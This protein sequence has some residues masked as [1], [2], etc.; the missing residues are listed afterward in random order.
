MYQ[1]KIIFSLMILFLISIFVKA[2]EDIIV[3]NL[4]YEISPMADY[5]VT[6]LNNDIETA[7]EHLTQYGIAIEPKSGTQ[8]LHS[9]INAIFITAFSSSD[10]EEE[11]TSIEI[12]ATSFD[13]AH[14]SPILD[15]QYYLRY[16]TDSQ[17]IDIIVGLAL[18]NASLFLEAEEILLEH[19]LDSPESSANFYIGNIRLFQQDYSAAIEYYNRAEINGLLDIVSSKANTAWALSQMDRQNDATTLINTTITENNSNFLI[20]MRL[21]AIRAQLYALALDYDSAIVDIDE[22]VAIAEENELDNSTLA[23]LYTIR[24]EIIFLIYEWDR[25]EENFNM[26]IELNPDYARAYFQRGVLFYTMARRDDALVDFQTYL[27]LEANGIYAEEAQSYI[28]SI[29]IELE[30]LGG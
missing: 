26:A 6:S 12:S 30:A 21:I 22:A 17:F 4:Y 23:E 7:N 25:V 19:I 8:P 18:Y 14:L 10:F 9:Q 2:Q 11:V 15:S 20:Q 27:D 28:E 3:V 29:E 16:E 1:V 13:I 5:S 24:G